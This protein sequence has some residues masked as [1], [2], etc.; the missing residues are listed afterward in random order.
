MI[1]D[2]FER[3]A[4]AQQVFPGDAGAVVGDDDGDVVEIRFR[5]QRHFAA[6]GRE[7][8]R[9]RQKI[10]RTCFTARGSAKIAGA[11]PTDAVKATPAS[12][13]RLATRRAHSSSVRS[14]SMQIGRAS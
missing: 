4:E 10:E 2:Q 9:V 12:E 11:W 13:A 3:R 14:S 5:R 7:F 6:G 8:D 1:L